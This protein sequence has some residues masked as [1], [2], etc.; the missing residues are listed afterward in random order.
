MIYIILISFY[1]Y[2]VIRTILTITKRGQLLVQ[3]IGPKITILEFFI[4]ALIVSYLFSYYY[5]QETEFQNFIIPANLIWMTFTASILLLGI[6]VGVRFILNVMENYLKD[7]EQISF[8]RNK[9]V[10]E[11]FSQVWVNV[12]MLMILFAYALMEIS[13]PIERITSNLNIISIYGLGL[14]LGILFYFSHRNVTPMVKR[15]TV[16]SMIF[17]SGS[18]SLFIWQ[19]QVDFIQN[20][21]VTTSFIVFSISFFLTLLIATR[22]K[23]RFKLRRGESVKENIIENRVIQPQLIQTSSPKLDTI[24]I[25]TPQFNEDTFA[26]KVLGQSS[27]IIKV[28]EEIPMA[29]EA[30]VEVFIEPKV[31]EE[32]NNKPVLS[33]KDW[34]MNG[35]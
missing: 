22:L 13:K 32:K 30:P 21:P 7:T 20:L 31:I 10:Y 1:T 19:S 9:E 14:L 5:F 27:N 6:G 26:A 35:G 25:Q 34:K 24:K 33:L 8:K 28:G 12:S 3:K 11:F 16:I 4:I 18:L 23:F 2:L 15:A 17:I 29:E